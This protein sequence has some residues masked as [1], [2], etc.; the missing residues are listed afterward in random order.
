MKRRT[1]KI[2]L[3]PGTLVHVGDKKAKKAKITIID[4]DQQKF[5]EITVEKVEDC[6]AYLENPTITWINVDGIHQ[7]EII[8]KLGSC[9]DLHPLV[10]EDI[11]NTGQRPKMEN[12]E[13][14][15]FFVLNMFY[16][17]E[18]I[19]EI[20]SEQ[21]SLILGPNF[22]ISFQEEEGD[23][24]DPV[25]KRLRNPKG[26]IKKEGADYLAY[27]LMDVIVDNYFAVLEKVGEKIEELEKQLVDEPTQKTLTDIHGLKRELL[28]LRK[29]VWP[30]REV[31]SN[32]TRTE[33]EL[34]TDNTRL[35]IRDVYDHTIQIM[36]TTD[37]YRDLL[38][39]LIDLYMSSISNKMNQVMQ[40]LTII[41]TIF[42]PLSFITGLYG[43]NFDQ[44]S[45]PFNMPVLGWY[46]GYIFV[47]AIMIAT[48]MIMIAY[49][50]IKKWF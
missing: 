14:Y 3:P 30:L 46:W 4:Y 10:Q 48:V 22:V 45:S 44:S 36:D 19:N 29:S 1:Q 40:V 12:F 21:V 20:K 34:I 9:F 17:N 13:K 35:Y 43:M 49:F 39:G 25:R 6:F 23:V 15:I 41:A 26:K 33:P 5:N 24:F 18:E 37:T 28:I 32:L 50:K 42:I 8:E 11:V 7:L 16:Y 2:G 47:W 31:L 27:A 38:S